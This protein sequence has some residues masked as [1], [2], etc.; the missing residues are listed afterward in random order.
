MAQQLRAHNALPEDQSLDSTIPIQ[1]IT[2]CLHLHLWRTQCPLL[3]PLRAHS[4]ALS[5]SC[6]KV[7]DVWIQIPALVALP[8]ACCCASMP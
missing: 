5:A 8:A 2:N 6:F 4:L 7:E 3:A 1:Q